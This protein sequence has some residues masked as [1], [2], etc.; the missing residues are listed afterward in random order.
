M[1]YHV[2]NF[3]IPIFQFKLD[4]WEEKKEKIMSFYPSDSELRYT[5]EVATDFT[6]NLPSVKRR[7]EI[8]DIFAPE[9]T[10]VMHTMG[11]EGWHVKQPW[12]EV[13]KKGD[14]HGPHTHGPI[15]M[16]AVCYVEFNKYEHTPTIF[17]PPFTDIFNSLT[18][19]YAPDAD[20]GTLVVFPASLLHWTERNASEQRRVAVSFNVDMSVG[21]VANTV[22]TINFND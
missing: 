15:G 2:H 5:G 22:Q 8:V 3:S 7:G 13:A 19:T 21:G 16:S 18:P 10:E 6:A 20:E 11:A 14:F 9:L 12:F 4:N 1:D 17:A